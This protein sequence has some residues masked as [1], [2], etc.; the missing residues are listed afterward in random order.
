MGVLGFEIDTCSQRAECAPWED[1]IMKWWWAPNDGWAEIC[2]SSM[3]RLCCSSATSGRTAGKYVNP[4]MMEVLECATVDPSGDAKCGHFL[5]H[6]QTL[7]QYR[8]PFYR[9]TL[10][11]GTLESAC[12]TLQFPAELTPAGHPQNATLSANTF[13]LPKWHSMTNKW[14][15]S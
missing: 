5:C 15:K 11:N 3:K 7:I 13:M 10:A 14:Y 2:L 12:L 9:S 8:L 4:F 1:T 6:S